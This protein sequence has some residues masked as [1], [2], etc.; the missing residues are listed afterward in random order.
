[1]NN[2][3]VGPALMG[4]GVILVL[5]GIVRLVTGDDD[6]DSA[7]TVASTSSSSTT[8]SSVP[9]EDASSTSSTTTSTSTSTTSTTTTTTTSTTTTALPSTSESPAEFFT[10][11]KAALDNG[12]AATLRDRMSEATIDRYGAEQCQSYAESVA[13]TGLDRVLV[14]TSELATWDYTTDGATTTIAG[15]TAAD[16]EQ[17][18]NGQTIGQTTHWQLVDGRYTWFTDC[19]TPV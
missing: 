2:K 4:L 10:V 15:V 7:S 1:M 3:Y 16:L 19:G 18:V 11:L 14:S 9:V 6:A 12:D 17:T 13:G 8:S 5:A